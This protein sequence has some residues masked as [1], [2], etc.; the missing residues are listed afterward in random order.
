M[1]LSRI[2]RGCWRRL[3][4]LTQRPP[5]PPKNPLLF[6]HIPKTAGTSVNEFLDSRFPPGQVH[7]I[8]PEHAKDRARILPKTPKACYTGHVY[9]ATRKLL[10][11]DAKVFTVLRDPIERAI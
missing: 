5:A 8:A 7:A 2:A 4:A 3:R 10:P 9:Y 11:P 6:V 1:D